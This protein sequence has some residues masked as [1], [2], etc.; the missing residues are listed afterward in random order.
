MNL[1]GIALCLLLWLWY[2]RPEGIENNK[3]GHTKHIVSGHSLIPTL[4]PRFNWEAPID[5]APMDLTS[6]PPEVPLGLSGVYDLP[7]DQE[8]EYTISEIMEGHPSESGGTSLHVGKIDTE[9]IQ[10]EDIWNFSA[11]QIP[12]RHVN[13]ISS[14]YGE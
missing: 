8:M 1:L 2:T 11:D 5:M 10:R 12:L 7:L 13:R 14:L 6:T 4:T 9:N 3:V